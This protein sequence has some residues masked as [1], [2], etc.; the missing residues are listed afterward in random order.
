MTNRRHENSADKTFVFGASYKLSHASAC[1][2][3]I[4]SL[5]KCW[6]V[7]RHAV[8]PIQVRALTLGMS[9]WV[10]FKVTEWDTHTQDILL[11]LLLLPAM[12]GTTLLTPRPRSALCWVLWPS[13][14]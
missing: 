10:T 9:Q 11:C 13:A 1:P 4:H 6:S 5:V 3:C 2:R 14:S 7:T 12:M 8:F